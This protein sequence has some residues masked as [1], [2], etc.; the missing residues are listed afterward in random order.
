VAIK[1]E[2][3]VP[4][5]LTIGIVAGI[6]IIVIIIGLQG[7]YQS[8]ENDEMAFKAELFKNADLIDL[9]AAQTDNISHYRWVDKQNNV[10]SIPIDRAM[11]VMIETNGNPPSTQPAAK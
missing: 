4:L 6:L 1:Q 10:V 2:A 5:V 11:Q 8:Q 3:N 9:K 7:W